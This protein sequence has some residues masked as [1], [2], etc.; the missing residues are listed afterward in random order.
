MGFWN[1]ESKMTR[2]IGGRLQDWVCG[3]DDC[4]GSEPSDAEVDGDM[5]SD[6]EEL[7]WRRRLII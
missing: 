5:E 2:C 1:A 7:S 6:E 3:C 4:F